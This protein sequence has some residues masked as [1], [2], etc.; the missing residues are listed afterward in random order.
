MCVGYLFHFLG[1]ILGPGVWACCKSAIIC[2]TPLKNKLQMFKSLNCIRNSE[3]SFLCFLEDIDFVIKILENLSDRSSGLSGTRLFHFY[4]LDLQDFEISRTNISRVIRYFCLYLWNCESNLVG[5]KSYIIG[6]GSHGHVHQVRQIWKW[7][8]FGFSQSEI[9][10]FLV[11]N[12][13]AWF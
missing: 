11:P 4:S 13:A 7:R 6:F 3:K 2:E 1:G 12:E 10:K 8:L 5:P 9:E